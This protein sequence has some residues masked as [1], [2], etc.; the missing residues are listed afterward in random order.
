M[1]AVGISP[2]ELVLPACS[3]D[4]VQR[5]SDD[6]DRPTVHRNAVLRHSPHDRMVADPRGIHKPID[7]RIRRDRNRAGTVV[8]TVKLT[9][10]HRRLLPLIQR[11]I[12]PFHPQQFI[13]GSFL[14]N[15][16]FFHNQ[17]Q[18]SPL[19]RCKSVSNQKH[20]P[21]LRHPL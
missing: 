14:S 19:Q 21:I 2:F 17:N 8:A 7:C 16:A 4:P 10:L 13:M 6:I 18:V 11:P 3:R 20:R 12:Q 15:D 9:R 1:R 5:I